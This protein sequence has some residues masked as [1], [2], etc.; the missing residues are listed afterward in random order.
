VAQRMFFNLGLNLDFLWEVIGEGILLICK[1]QHYDANMP[2]KL[3]IN[4]TSC[5]CFTNQSSLIWLA[6]K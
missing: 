5:F 6:F 3:T 2:T 4:V 1:H